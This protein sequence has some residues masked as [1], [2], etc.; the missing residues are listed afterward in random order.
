M[1]DGS[2]SQK[3]SSSDGLVSF[4]IN[5]FVEATLCWQSLADDESTTTFFFKTWWLAVDY[6]FFTGEA[7]PVWNRLDYVDDSI[8]IIEFRE[9]IIGLTLETFLCIIE[10]GSCSSSARPFHCDSSP[11][12]HV[13]AHKIMSFSNCRW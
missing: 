5:P 1:M 13:S 10:L 9:T 3:L 6:F 8:Q 4:P 12:Q 2:I 7:F 11:A